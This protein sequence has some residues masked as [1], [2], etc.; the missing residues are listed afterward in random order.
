MV[1]FDF[2][3]Q[4]LVETDL[5]HRYL[6][7]ARLHALGDHGELQETVVVQVVTFLDGPTNLDAV[8]GRRSGRDREHIVK[9]T[10]LVEFDRG[11]R[12]RYRQ[13]ERQAEQRGEQQ[14]Q[15]P[16]G[17]PCHRSSIPLITQPR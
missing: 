11:N 14:E 15:P 10:D 4:Q 9:I 12:R 6:R 5:A 16:G 13:A 7:L 17:F 8:T 1:F 2:L 3:A